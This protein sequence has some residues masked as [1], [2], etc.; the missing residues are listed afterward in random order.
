[1]NYKKG[2]V[3]PLIIAIVAILAIGGGVYLDHYIKTNPKNIIADEVG[4]G[5]QQEGCKITAHL[6]D[7]NTSTST[8]FIIDSI[9][10][11]TK[12]CL[13]YTSPSPRDS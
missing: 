2:F 12:S 1:M 9:T 3:I 8:S 6:L 10:L 5:G 11:L 7:L 4:E 13:L